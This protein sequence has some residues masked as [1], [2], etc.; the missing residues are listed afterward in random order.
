MKKYHKDTFDNISEEKRNR[1]MDVAIKEFAA[2]GFGGTN[3]N[4]IASKAG[5]SVGS[6][7]RY[8]DSKEDLFL[9]MVDMG[10]K[11]LDSR[12]WPII[13]GEGDVYEKIEKIMI[14][15]REF[16]REQPEVIQ[17]YLDSTTEG[18]SELSAELSRKIES[19]SANYYRSLI[20]AAKE[21]GMVTADVDDG[22]IAFFMDNIFIMIQYAY[23]SSYFKER[24]RVYMGEDV[25]ADDA[26]VIEGMMTLVRR[27]LKS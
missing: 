10:Y 13:A 22:I 20:A 7:Y 5:I 3:I 9:S 2:K 11:Y 23:A 17:I 14:Q 19:I 26:R 18:L 6:V 15:A 12:L 16:S 24:M 1:I 4:T 21:N 8:F 27:A 25:V